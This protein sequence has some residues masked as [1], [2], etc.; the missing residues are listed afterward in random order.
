MSESQELLPFELSWDDT[1][2]SVTN[3]SGLLNAP[4]GRDGFITVEDGQFVDGSGDRFRILG[5]NMSFSGNFPDHSDAADVAGRLAKFGINCVRLHHVDTR[6]APDGIWDA[7]TETKQQLDEDR[8]DRLDHFVAEL[9]ARG[10]YVNINLK[11]GREAVEADG[12]PFPDDLP[13]FDI[14][15]DHFYPRL[16]ELQQEY[17]RR[18]LTHENPY[19]ETRYVDEPAVATIEINNESGLVF[20]WANGSLDGLPEPYEEVL[21]DDW[22]AYLRVEYDWNDNLRAVWDA[23]AL[24][25]GSIPLIQNEG[26]GEWPRAVQHAWISFLQWRER[27]YNRTMYEFIRDELGA[28]QPITGTQIGFASH[29]S[30][31]VH[32]LIDAHGYWNHPQFPGESWDSQEWVVE[33]VSIVNSDDSILHDLMT[34]QM[35]GAPYTVS[36]YNHP[37]PNTYSSEAIPL[38]A[39]YAAFQ[40]WD[41]IYMYSYS[42]TNEYGTRSINNFFDIV[43]HTPKMLMMPVAAHLFLRGDVATAHSTV[44]TSLS[45]EK[46]REHLIE[47]EGGLWDMPLLSEDLP[48][49]TSLIHRTQLRY[50]EDPEPAQRSDIDGS[51][52]RHVTDTDEVVWDRTDPEHSYV[53]VET[54]DTKGFVGFVPDGPIRLGPDLSL[55]IGETRQS[56]ANVFVTNVAETAE[57]TRWLLVASGYAENKGM[58]WTNAEK[59]SVGEN[60]GSGPPLVEPI[61]LKLTFGTSTPT[62]SVYALDET[63][64]RQEALETVDSNG[65][66]LEIDLLDRQPSLWYEI[67]V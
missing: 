18:L 36:E 10:I 54:A 30:Q 56:W 34:G 37:A 57:E 4:A 29:D 32:D 25:D 39:T 13:R 8:L 17:A 49:T 43:G 11:I 9:K 38:L 2:E 63:G 44:T 65:D 61:P 53:T 1:T 59:S 21:R 22:H 28:N 33:N 47:A 6:R 24:A 16:I 51:T 66:A 12:V 31:E 58:E 14:G 64:Q 41:G 42:H 5:V 15:P 46:L 48:A 23:E 62:A 7:D 50:G 67:A 40:D 45:R 60:W 20:Q 52:E 19:T 55:T 3:V 26:F 35:E 27:A